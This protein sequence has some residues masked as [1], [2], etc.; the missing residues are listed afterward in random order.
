MICSVARFDVSLD[1][2]FLMYVQMI[3]GLVKVAEWLLLGNS[4]SSVYHILSVCCLCCFP[5]CFRWCGAGFW[6]WLYTGL[7]LLFCKRISER[8][9]DNA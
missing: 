4:C 2:V 3:F 1:T 7:L 5:F 9:A 8:K 6:F